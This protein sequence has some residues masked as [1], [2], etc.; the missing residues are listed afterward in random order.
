MNELQERLVDYL[1]GDLSKLPEI[2]DL[3]L[4]AIQKAVMKMSSVKSSVDNLIAAITEQDERDMSSVK[5][6]VDN[7]FAAIAEQEKRLNLV[8][9]SSPKHAFG[10]GFI[11]GY[12]FAIHELSSPRQIKRR[13]DRQMTVRDIMSAFPEIYDMKTKV[14]VTT[15]DNKNMSFMMSPLASIHDVKTRIMDKLGIPPEQLKLSTGQ[16]QDRC[17][18]FGITVNHEVALQ[19]VY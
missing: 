3:D 18:L 5:S 7:L 16:L 12:E 2:S 6:S 13:G 11:W 10:S 17:R 1:M 19:C 15:G 9:V 14:N 8:S 4:V